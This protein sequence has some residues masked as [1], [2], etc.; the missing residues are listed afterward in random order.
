MQSTTAAVQTAEREAEQARERLTAAE[1]R[2]AAAA[3]ERDDR[4]APYRA[5]QEAAETAALEALS[6]GDTETARKHVRQW[7]R[8]EAAIQTRTKEHQRRIKNAEADMRAARR[9]IE[10]AE[11]ARRVA[12]R[13]WADPCKT[14]ERMWGIFQQAQAEGIGLRIEMDDGPFDLWGAELSE[15]WDELEPGETLRLIDVLPAR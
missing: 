12:E 1:A 5:Q 9:G 4:A 14:Y 11:A 2:R 10:D 6:A 3:A 7:G 8:A 15:L 13:G